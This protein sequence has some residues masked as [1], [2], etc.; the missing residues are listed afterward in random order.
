MEKDF[1]EIMKELVNKC[2][3]IFEAQ[4]PDDEDYGLSLN[5]AICTS[6]ISSSE[7]YLH[8]LRTEDGQAFTWHRNGSNM[9][10]DINGIKNVMVDVYQLFLKGKEYKIIYI[11]PYGYN[12]AYVPKGFVLAKEELN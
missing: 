3:I 11:C 2:D 6:S 7:R 12:S 9:V 10:K 4:R 1:A 5:N 8:L